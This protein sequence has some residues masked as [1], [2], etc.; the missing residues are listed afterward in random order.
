[1]L[2]LDEAT[3]ALDTVTEKLVLNSIKNFNTNITIIMITHR[4]STVLGSN[5]VIELEEGQIKTFGSYNHVV[6]TSSSFRGLIQDS[7]IK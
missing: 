6:K 4:T 7:K 1:M 2:I 3:S 5:K